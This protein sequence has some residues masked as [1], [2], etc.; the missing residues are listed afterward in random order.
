M[1]HGGGAAEHNKQ[2]AR[3]RYIMEKRRDDAGEAFC[4]IRADSR[5]FQL[6]P[7]EVSTIGGKRF[8]VAN[9]DQL[10]MVGGAAPKLWRAHQKLVGS[11]TE[12]RIPFPLI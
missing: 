2:N 1:Q 4:R 12:S 3:E 6:N 10:W 8:R 7:Q 11:F 5:L 9:E